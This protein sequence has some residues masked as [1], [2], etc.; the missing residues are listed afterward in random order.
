[1]GA[2]G[3]NS[4]MFAKYFYPLNHPPEPIIPSEDA[5]RNCV[6]LTSTYPLKALHW[7]SITS[8]RTELSIHEALGDV[9]SPHK[10]HSISRISMLRQTERQQTGR[11][12]VTV[13][14]STSLGPQSHSVSE[15]WK[16][17]LHCVFSASSGLL[18]TVDTPW[19]AGALVI[20]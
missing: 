1:M 12:W 5:P 2:R 11:L 9:P 10:N 8:L 6:L 20:K 14:Y 13:V 17:I 18:V 19:L 4:G 7:S 15:T 3:L 16:R